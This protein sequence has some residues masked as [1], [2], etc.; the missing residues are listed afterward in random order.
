MKK[1]IDYSTPIKEFV[2]QFVSSLLWDS[3]IILPLFS[4][5]T[6]GDG[7]YE[8]ITVQLDVI[9]T[10]LVYNLLDIYKKEEYSFSV[11]CWMIICSSLV[12]ML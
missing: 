2:S 10:I 1:Q 4:C 3:C 6:C 8:W 5:W 9:L 12:D 11:D 7:L